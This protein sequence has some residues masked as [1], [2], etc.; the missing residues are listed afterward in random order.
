MCFTIWVFNRADTALA[1]LVDSDV[2]LVKLPGVRDAQRHA[3]VRD[4]HLFSSQ[5]R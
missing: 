5:S 1:A 2:P 4:N 3:T